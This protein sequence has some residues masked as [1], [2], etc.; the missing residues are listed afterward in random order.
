MGEDANNYLMRLGGK[1]GRITSMTADVL[2]DAIRAGHDGAQRTWYDN[3]DLSPQQIN[4]VQQGLPDDVKLLALLITFNECDWGF[5]RHGGESVRSWFQR[6]ADK[7]IQVAK[8]AYQRGYRRATFGGAPMGCYDWTDEETR[9]EFGNAYR[10]MY[11]NQTLDGSPGG[12]P[13]EWWF[14]GH[15]Y[16]PN[17][18]WLYDSRVV[19]TVALADDPDANLGTVLWEDN[20]TLNTKVHA[21]S[22][23]V[24]TWLTPG[25]FG[26]Q[27]YALPPT[28]RVIHPWDWYLTRSNFLFWEEMGILFDPRIRRVWASEGLFD[29]GGIGGGRAHGYSSIFTH[30]QILRMMEILA[31]PIVV[32]GKNYEQPHRG[33]TIFTSAKSDAK[34]SNGFG[35]DYVLSDPAVDVTKWGSA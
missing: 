3:V 31:M 4:D 15:C 10:G 12:I 11:N 22:G 35:I 18:T 27:N 1:K 21:R 23:M 6:Q 25:P 5:G 29:E 17:A 13:F 26:T 19:P 34:W 20:N 7:T 30:K 14:D 33:F 2:R 28:S 32:N 24:M 16:V 9:I 8:I